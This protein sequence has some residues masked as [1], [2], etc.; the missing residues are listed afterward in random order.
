MKQY[1]EEQQLEYLKSPEYY[2]EVLIGKPAKEKLLKRFGTVHNIILQNS[3]NLIQAGLPEKKAE[4]LFAAKMLREHKTVMIKEGQ[5]RCSQD[6][7]NILYKMGEY[8]VE[9]FVVALLNRAN[10]VLD[11]RTVSQGGTSGT[12][13]DTKVLFQTVLSY[14]TCNAIVL[15]HNHPSNNLSPSESDL[16]LTKK[17]VSGAAL[18]DIKVLDHLII[19][20]S[21]YL[22]FADEGYL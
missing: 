15:A 21:H 9:H 22:S 5:I 2:L 8:T 7:Y 10:K 13:V 12:V 6:L 3:T 20:Y 14:P 11:V 1:V 17:I 19:G 16:E 18:L 4:V